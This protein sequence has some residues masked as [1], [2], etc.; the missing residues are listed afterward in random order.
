M[1]HVRSALKLDWP[2]WQSLWQF[3]FCP[4]FQF[5]PI[6]LGTFPGLRLFSAAQPRLQTKQALV[7]VLSFSLNLFCA[8]RF[9]GVRPHKNAPEKAVPF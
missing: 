1:A 3:Y 8:L 2:S 7:F 5:L 6:A 4:L 9:V